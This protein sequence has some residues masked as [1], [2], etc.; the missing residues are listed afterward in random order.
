ME[1]A[2]K[3]SCENKTMP[4]ETAILGYTGEF[5]S[6]EFDRISRGLIPYAMEDKWF[7]YLDGNTLYMHRSW[8]GNCIYQVEFEAVA[9]KHIVRCALVNRDQTQYKS[10]DDVYDA[11]LLHFLISNLLLGKQ[12]EFPV[13]GAVSKRYAKGSFQ[14]NVS[15]TAYPE[16]LLDSNPPNTPVSC[17]P[18]WKLW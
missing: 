8:T 3:D 4:Q 7:I 1:T 15:G 17:K 6:E 11:A 14:H 12:D 18:W 2:R 16:K 13:P 10:T 9:E 5:S